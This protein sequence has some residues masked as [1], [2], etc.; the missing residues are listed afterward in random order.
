MRFRFSQTSKRSEDEAEISVSF[1]IL[2]VKAQGCLEFLARAIQLVIHTEHQPQL[3]MRLI[4]VGIQLRGRAKMLEG[5]NAVS[6]REECLAQ[7]SVSFR[8][9]GVEAQTICVERKRLL[10]CFCK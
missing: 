4:V 6:R 10:H 2:R 1:S 3:V 5:F 8:I 7:P 9:V